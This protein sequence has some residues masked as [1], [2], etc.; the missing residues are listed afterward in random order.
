MTAIENSIF[1]RNIGVITEQEQQKLANSKVTVVGAGGVG[2]IALVSLARMGFKNIHVIDMD[3]FEYSNINRQMLSSVSRIGK[4]KAE[5]AK[6]TL[7]DI[8]PNINVTV[9]LEMFNENNAQQLLKDC[10]IVIDAT[11]N[12]VTRVII[13]RAAQKMQI[14]SVWIAVT[15]PF[16]G[17]VMTFSHET[18]A[19]EIVLRHCSY[20]KELTPDVKNEIMKIKNERALNSVQFGALEDW[21][22]SFVEK[23]APWTVLCPVANIVGLLASFEVLK[24]ILNRENLQPTYAPKLVKI[25]LAKSDMVKVESPVEG[26]WDNALL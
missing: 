24:Y 9:S 19:Y 5:C 18:P 2:G 14:P 8:N 21:A 25:D 23:S 13:H 1:M 22:N 16:R 12:L 26:T 11:D 3:K 10:E 7:M 17:G 4:Y 20:N 6:E 15:P